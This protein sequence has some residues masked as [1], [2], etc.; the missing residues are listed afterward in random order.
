METLQ[1]E[2]FKRLVTSYYDTGVADVSL[3]V[4]QPL[5]F[6]PELSLTTVARLVVA[7]IILLPVLLI[8]VAFL[9][10]RGFRQRRASKMVRS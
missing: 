6:T 1:P 7:A 8:L 10:L 9:G 4:Y 5:Q 2:G 3:Y